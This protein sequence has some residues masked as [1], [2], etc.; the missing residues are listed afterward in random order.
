MSRLGPR[1]HCWKV[2]GEIPH[3]QYL[4]WLQMK[5]QANYR[6]EVFAISFEEFRQLWQGQWERK[7]RGVE[8]YCLTR[9]DPTG[10]W[11]WGNVLCMPRIE[12]LRRQKLYKKERKH[13]Y[14][15]NKIST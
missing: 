12:H 8:D 15:N 1:P 3:A 5:A 4:A 10:A 9:E 13:G 2:Q 6:R 11:I 14:Q 7:G